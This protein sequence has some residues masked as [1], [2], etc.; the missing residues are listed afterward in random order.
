MQQEEQDYDANC[1]TCNCEAVINLPK[2]DTKPNVNS[3]ISDKYLSKKPKIGE[4]LAKMEREEQLAKGSHQMPE[5]VNSFDAFDH[6]V[7]Q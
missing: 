5:D 7:E 1:Q 3:A 4:I 6:E 2:E